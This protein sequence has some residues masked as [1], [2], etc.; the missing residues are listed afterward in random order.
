MLETLVSSRIR[1]ALLEYVLTHP[2]DRF[3]LRG[4]A[5]QLELSI[6]PLRRELK[7]L[8][9]A[10]L[11]TAE[12]E[13]NILF[14]TVNVASPLF[15][16]LQHAPTST[17]VVSE[18]AG[19]QAEAPSA[20]AIKAPSLPAALPSPEPGAPSHS[21]TAPASF[22]SSWSSPLRTPALI[23]AAGV[24]MALILIVAS[25]VYLTMTNQRLVSQATRMLATR[26][27]QVTVVDAKPASSGAMRSSRW[28]LL[29][30]GVGGFSSGAGDESY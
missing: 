8:E 4:L 26:K 18:P 27:A 23:A 29:P 20:Q 6:S 25:L 16:Q 24:G 9:R 2:T 17:A 22:W 7:R 21:S 30:G 14:Y 13:A 1:R 10:G 19:P 15:V 5:K 3:Y 11:L 12:Q 28:Q